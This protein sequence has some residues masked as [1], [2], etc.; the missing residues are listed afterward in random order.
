MTADELKEQH[1]HLI[2]RRNQLLAAA[3][4]VP[5]E[6]TTEETA[7]RV[8]DFVKQMAA[9]MKAVEDERV[10]AK[11]PILDAGRIVDAFF[12]NITA[13][14]VLEKADIENRLTD[15]QL[16]RNVEGKIRGEFGSVASI[17]E[18]WTF[19]DLDPAIIDLEQLRP[20]IAIE[21]IQQ[22]VRR[23]VRAG[24]RELKGVRIFPIQMTRVK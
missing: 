21:A 19:S 14:L 10:A 8:A 15:Y 4:R 18:N 9:L 13:T 1:A 17:K 11:A 16:R 23:F 2:E 3:D 24:G 22:A 6:I 12:R 7:Q 5:L 20:H